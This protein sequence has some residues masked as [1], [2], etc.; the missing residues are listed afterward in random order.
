MS[1]WTSS[2][3]NYGY[4]PEMHFKPPKDASFRSERAADERLGKLQAARNRLRES[5]LE[6]QERQK[7]ETVGNCSNGG[8][9]A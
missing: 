4:H 5:I 3:K 9:P 1:D 8:A 7:A 6:A 2:V